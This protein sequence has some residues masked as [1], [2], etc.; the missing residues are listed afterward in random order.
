[1]RHQYR[2]LIVG[3]GLAGVSAVEGI[4]KHDPHGS[5]GLLCA[6]DMP[7]YN[8]PPLSKDLLWG[9]KRLDQIFIHD[10]SFYHLQGVELHLET[11][12]KGIHREERF[13]TDGKGHCYGYSKLLIATGG[14][15][16]TVTGGDGLVHYLHGAEDYLELELALATKENFLV[17]GG[18]FIGAEV[19][20]GLVHQRKTVV[21]VTRGPAL[22]SKVLPPDLAAFVTDYFRK[23]GV[24][25]V[26][27]DQARQFIPN[28][29]GVTVHTQDGKVLESDW[30]IAGVGLKPETGLA[31]NAGLAVRDGIVTNRYLQTS[32][33]AIF[34][35][36]D[37]VRFPCEALGGDMRVEH[38]DNARVQ[39][40]C[41]GVN[42]AGGDEPYVYLP[43]FFSDLFDLGFEAV[44]KLDSRMP[45]QA[46]W[47]EPFRKGVVAYLDDQKVRGVLLWNKPDKV[48]WARK[49]ILD[50]AYLEFEE[51]LKPVLGGS[52]AV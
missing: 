39:G 40:R 27:G 47:D 6:E 37:S 35:A 51:D 32:D 23:K 14:R 50:Q 29:G 12:V 3:G 43:S 18:G 9:K 10:K 13:V 48:E 25:V 1:M 45:T 49:V 2:Y 16:R 8:R 11:T 4:R 31:E 17:L 7:P 24:T 41:A 22:L 44:G 19:A 5:I 26:T 28:G 21:L 30:V 15:P 33:A 20:A 42:M 36:G 46:L 34:A 52:Q 38:W